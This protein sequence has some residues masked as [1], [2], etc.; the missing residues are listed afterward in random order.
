[1]SLPQ[2]KT[3]PDPTPELHVLP[4]PPPA[5]AEPKKPAKPAGG[6]NLGGLA[7][8]KPKAKAGD[9]RPTIPGD[10]ELE[11]LADTF[12]AEKPEFDALEGRLKLLRAEIISR[13]F[14]AWLAAAA[15]KP[16]VGSLNLLGKLPEK[17]TDERTRLLVSMQNRYLTL[18]EFSAGQ[19]KVLA[20]IDEA[21]FEQAFEPGLSLALKFAEI[22][23]AKRQEVIDDLLPIFEKH[24]LMEG[25]EP[26]VACKQVLQPR[27]GFH[28]LRHTLFTPAENL[29]L[30][31]IVPCVGMVKLTGLRK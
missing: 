25:D 2:L 20:I 3:L 12:A 26:A 27:P 17:A 14:P 23:E 28:T 31:E 10:P 22:P 9:T 15:Q 24:G 4:S 6:L 16:D 11:E 18:P 13:T 7:T 21:R 8:A 29:A 30:H 19:E 1:M 5:P